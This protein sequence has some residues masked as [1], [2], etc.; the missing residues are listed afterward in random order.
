MMTEFRGCID[1][2][3]A[4]KLVMFLSG[5]NTSSLIL[6]VSASVIQP[7]PFPVQIPNGQAVGVGPAH[8]NRP[9][10]GVPPNARTS[11][12]LPPVP[13]MALAPGPM[14]R[15]LEGSPMILQRGLIQPANMH[16][17]QGNPAIMHPSHGNPATIPDGQMPLG[18]SRGPPARG[19]LASSVYPPRSMSAQPH[20]PGPW[21]NPQ[22][23]IPPD[24]SLRA[25]PSRNPPGTFPYGPVMGNNQPFP[26]H[27]QVP[28][29]PPHGAQD[30]SVPEPM[31]GG[32]L[33]KSPSTPSLM[34]P[35][36][37]ETHPA[38]PPPPNGY[39]HFT[40]AANTRND[41]YGSMRA[42]PPRPMLP[43]ALNVRSVSMSG[44]SF[45]ASPPGSP[46]EER[47]PVG[48]VTSAISAQMKCKVFLQQQ[49]AQWKSLGP[50]KLKLYKQHPTN[51]KQLVVEADNKGKS[52]LISTIVL[53]DGVERVG[54]TGVAVELSDKGARTGIVYMLQLRNETSAKG[55]FDSLLEGSDRAG[56]G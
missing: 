53:T 40:P 6:V 26:S 52:I 39:Q 4:G 51:V 43:S 56:R 32:G 23:H 13:G 31:V 11:H 5:P 16:P 55:L 20:P 28:G 14:N 29:F 18:A 36:G 34:S 8:I 2:A 24:P 19:P 15:P 17:G 54:K 12:E 47:V 22:M 45:N 35:P 46:V 38:L 50:A 41:P 21:S 30:R 33:R 27:S 3:S 1:F 25:G 7:P 48:P 44:P 49:H 37:F 10:R 42:P 9:P